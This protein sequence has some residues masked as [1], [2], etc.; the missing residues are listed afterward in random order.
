MPET[1]TRTTTAQK[2]FMHW[3]R[4]LARLRFGSL[5]VKGI[6]TDDVALRAWHPD[7]YIEERSWWHPFPFGIQVSIGDFDYFLY[8]DKQKTNIIYVQDVSEAEPVP[9][10]DCD[11]DRREAETLQPD[12]QEWIHELGFDQDV[13]ES[14]LQFMAAFVA[15]ARPLPVPF[16]EESDTK[17]AEK[18]MTVPLDHYADLV[19]VFNCLSI[20]LAQVRYA[21]LV[22]RDYDRGEVTIAQQPVA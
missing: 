16:P 17:E 20:G 3:A 13:Y 7:P 21:S 9:A 22:V 5:T 11:F 12:V 18:A 4:F 2:V 6:H 8:T 10:L 19:D 15:F 1:R 14:L